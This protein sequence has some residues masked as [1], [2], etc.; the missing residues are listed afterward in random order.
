MKSCQENTDLGG[1]LVYQ[2]RAPFLSVVGKSLHLIAPLVLRKFRMVL[3]LLMI[4][5]E[6]GEPLQS[7]GDRCPHNIP[8]ESA[9]VILLLAPSE[10]DFEGVIIVPTNRGGT[11]V[12][13]IVAGRATRGASLS[14]QILQ[15]LGR[16]ARL[17]D[18]L[19]LFSDRGGCVLA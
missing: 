10:G 12:F 18:F 8:R 14:R 17:L 15:S 4:R 19:S 3:K 11:L 7:R 2:V 1:R 6:I 16:V 5:R 13:I 9:D